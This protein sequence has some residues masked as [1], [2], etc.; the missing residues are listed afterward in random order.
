MAIAEDPTKAFQLTI[1][2][3]RVA[4]ISDG[5]AARVS[6]TSDRSA[7]CPSWRA[8][9]CSSDSSPASTR[10]RSRSTRRTPARSSRRHSH[11]AGLRRHQSRGY[12]GAALLRGRG[13]PDRLARHSGDAR[14]SARHRGRDP[15]GDDRRRGV[16]SKRFEDM[17]IVLAGSGAA[18]TA[19]IK[20]L[21]AAG[22]RDVIP[23]DRDGAITATGAT[24]TRTGAGSP[25][26]QP[27]QPAGA[28]RATSCRAPTVHRGTAP[29]I[30][31]RR[32]ISQ[33]WGAIRSCSRW[34]TPAPEIMPDVAAPYAAVIATGR[35]TSRTRSTTCWP[36]RAFP[37]RSRTC[38]RGR[39]SEGMKLAAASRDR[40]NRDRGGAQPGVHY[41]QRIRH[42]RGRCGRPGGRRGGGRGRRC[43][44]LF[45]KERKRRLGSQRLS[46]TA[47]QNPEGA[48]VMSL[49]RIL[50]IEDDE[51]VARLEQ[52][53]SSGR[54]MKCAVHRERCRGFGIGGPR[55]SP[56][57]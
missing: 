25:N 30:L 19:T 54:A 42:P 1:K 44:A 53:S 28:A 7:R 45:G 29:D 13:T 5:T 24:T 10:F 22:V 52:T 11:R 23:V 34:P 12:L 32:S 4:V 40:R 16:V 21:L 38:G 35:R 6:A 3:N 33:R 9:P 49:A 46:P 18:G 8:S 26:M 41:S 14:R 36:S 2:R 57:S 50:V 39:I 48:G 17:T 37:R 20:M 51:D 56:T 47:S 27:R 43:P 31:S 55:T 15:G